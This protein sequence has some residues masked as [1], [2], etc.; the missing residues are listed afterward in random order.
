VSKRRSSLIIVY[1]SLDLGGIET[2]ILNICQSLSSQYSIILALKNPTGQLLKKIPP[3]V[4][5][6]HPSLSSPVLFPFW[7]AKL[8][9]FTKPKLIL[10]FSNFCAI[11]SVIARIISLQKKS[12]LIISEDS[13]IIEQIQSDSYPQI[14]K[15]LVQITYPLANQIVVLTAVGKNKLISLNPQLASKINL[16]PNWLPLDFP[17]P[18]RIYTKTIDLL[19]LGR[20]DQAK[21]PLEFIDIS[22]QLISTNPNLKIAMIGHGPML[23][24]IKKLISRYKLSPQNFSL[25]SSTN[26]NY[27]FF[28]KAKIFLL[29]SI[30]EGFP[31]TILE[32]TA[33]HCLPLCR[34]LPELQIFFSQHHQ[35]LF[36]NQAQAITK[37][38]YLLKNPLVTAKLSNFYFQKT[39]QSQAKNLNL[40]LKL[41]Q[42]YLTV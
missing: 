1:N 25:L 38:N 29:P 10:G 22:H 39:T 7:L 24:Q 42:R 5:I 20:F 31:L 19:F 34:S 40:T 13:S 33:S 12:R 15:R 36:S 11:S 14:R 17:H 9:F 8:F 21:N 2:K 30:R 18:S 26:L 35:L 32:A 28:Q 41:I 4:I 27:H 3:S 6:K 37:I 16:C 23:P